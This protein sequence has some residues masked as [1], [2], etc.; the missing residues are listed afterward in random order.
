MGG[1]ADLHQNEEG[2]RAGESKG[3]EARVGARDWEGNDKTDEGA[4]GAAV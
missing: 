2:G 3:V 1:A 4:V